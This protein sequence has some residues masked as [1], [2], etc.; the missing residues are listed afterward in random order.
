MREALRKEPVREALR[1]EAVDTR[2][3][4]GET[5]LF[6]ASTIQVAESLV[7]AGAKVE[8]ANYK[9]T[10]FLIENKAGPDVANH[11][12]DTCLHAA[13]SSGDT[14]I[15]RFLLDAGANAKVV[16]AAGAGPLRPPTFQSANAKVVNAAGDGPLHVAC[17]TADLNAI[18]V[19]P[20]RDG[21]LHVACRTADLNAIKALV[22]AG[23]KPKQ[24]T[25][26]G[27]TPLHEAC[28]FA[29]LQTVKYLIQTVK[30][31]IQ[32]GADVNAA[33]SKGRI[34]LQNAVKR[35]HTG[36]LEE[37]C[38]KG[39]DVRIIEELCDKGVD[40][41]CLAKEAQLR[42]HG[43]TPLHLGAEVGSLKLLQ[44]ITKKGSDFTNPKALTDKGE[45]AM[46]IARESAHAGDRVLKFLAE[47]IRVKKMA[48][49]SREKTGESRSSDKKAPDSKQLA[50]HVPS[51]ERAGFQDGI[52]P[53][54]T[55]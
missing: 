34:P 15:L 11:R 42:G 46:D 31:L 43:W 52:A 19:W 53:I 8:N 30:Y 37:L 14:S 27:V 49:G 16:N 26:T 24:A 41:S 35:K 45:T 50:R 12:G 1:K 22:K 5:A 28:H 23:A 7:A 2:D 25:N 9:V 40:V 29:S 6:W 51:A 44:L 17:R 54:N 21:P 47:Q 18:K 48:G 32:R 36:I 55:N 33:T 39:V 13:A 38:N 20:T 3:I 4:W 10:Q